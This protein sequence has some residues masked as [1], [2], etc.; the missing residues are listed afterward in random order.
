MITFLILS[1]VD[2][3]IQVYNPKKWK[4]DDSTIILYHGDAACHYKS[5]TNTAEMTLMTQMTFI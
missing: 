2:Q 5:S 1:S 4:H 3:G